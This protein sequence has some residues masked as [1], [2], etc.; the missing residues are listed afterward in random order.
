VGGATGVAGGQVTGKVTGWLTR[1]MA[2][3]YWVTPG[4]IAADQITDEQV[5]VSQPPPK[6]TEGLL[7]T[8]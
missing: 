2:A 4:G 5:A 7:S 6:V 1:R 8:M 3:A